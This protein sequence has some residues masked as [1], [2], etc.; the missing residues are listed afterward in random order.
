MEAENKPVFASTELLIK[1]FSIIYDDI[2]NKGRE[3]SETAK[4]I[5]IMHPIADSFEAVAEFGSGTRTVYVVS[6]IK[7]LCKSI[8]DSD[9]TKFDIM[10]LLDHVLEMTIA[11]EKI[12]Y[13][14]CGILD[15]FK[16]V[17]DQE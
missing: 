1:A 11:S 16:D 14:Y 17:T 6:L 9:H 3:L 7:E 5:E 10:R 8:P 13:I 2:F 15:H 4:A 12:T